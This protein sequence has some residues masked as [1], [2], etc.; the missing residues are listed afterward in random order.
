[1]ADPDWRRPRSS[2]LFS[3]DVL[4]TEELAVTTLSLDA[5][6]ELAAELMLDPLPVLAENID[7]VGTDWTVS[8]NRVNADRAVGPMRGPRKLVFL[9]LL[10][11]SRKHVAAVAYRVSERGA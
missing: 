10:I 3:E 7:G 2:E 11:Y 9:L 8:V 5:D 6:S 1:M 4:E